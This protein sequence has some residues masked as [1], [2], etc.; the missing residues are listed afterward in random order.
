[1]FLQKKN[2]SILN[3]NNFFKLPDLICETKYAKRSKE[4]GIK[5][6]YLVIKKKVDKL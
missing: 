5:P 6:K 4:C 1:M 2:F 3:Q